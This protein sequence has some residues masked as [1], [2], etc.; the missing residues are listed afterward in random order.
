M[1]DTLNGR[2]RFHTL[3]VLDEGAREGLSI[4]MDASLPAE[5]VIRGLERVV[6]WRGRPQALRLDNGPELIAERFMTWCTERGI[7]LRYIQ[8]DKPDRN[9]FIE[10]FNYDVSNESAQYLSV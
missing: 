9:A 1:S 7:E 4:E 6:S 10:R 5:R 8:T 3:N 2:R